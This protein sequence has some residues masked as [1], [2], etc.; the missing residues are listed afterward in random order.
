MSPTWVDW[1]GLAGS[2]LSFV[3]VWI[4]IWQIVKTRRVA[5]ATQRASRTAL[6]AMGRQV[7]LSEVTACSANLTTIIEL[8]RTKRYE[9]VSLRV[10]DLMRQLNHIRNMPDAAALAAFGQLLTQLYVIRELMDRR[11]ADPR[12]EVR[13]VEVIKVL[14]GVS[15]ELNELVGRQKYSLPEAIE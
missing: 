7:V 8:V 10:S 2:G 15:D 9:A 13:P 14:N 1:V 11:L 12:V 6:A 5:E 3:S 4:A